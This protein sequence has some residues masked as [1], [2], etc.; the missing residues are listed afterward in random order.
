METSHMSAIDQ[1]TKSL[2]KEIGSTTIKA[3]SKSLMSLLPFFGEL[4]N[5]TVP[6]IYKACKERQFNDFLQGIGKYIEQEQFSKEQCKAFEVKLAT[7]ETYKYLSTI[8]DSVF[9]SKSSRARI[10]LGIVMANY[11]H[12]DNIPYEDLI[13]TNVLKELIDD[14]MDAFNK[15]FEV[16]IGGGKEDANG[17]GAFFINYYPESVLINTTFC[18]LKNLNIVGDKA[19][20][21]TSRSPASWHGDVTSITKKL[22]YYIDLADKE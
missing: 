5:S 9:F 19:M 15:I 14:E 12:S 7:L 1:L 6:N 3:I 10:V 17:V 16:A 21:L 8:I 2:N 18:K 4:I 11:I 20:D 13:I 22:K